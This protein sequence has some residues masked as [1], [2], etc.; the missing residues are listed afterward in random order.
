M[1]VLFCFV[2]VKTYIRKD[3]G[4][5]LA[6]SVMIRSSAEGFV[7][8]RVMSGRHRPVDHGGRDN[9]VLKRGWCLHGRR[10]GMTE[11]HRRGSVMEKALWVSAG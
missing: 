9:A 8:S 1:V 2:R 3:Q 10:P 7:E 6:A 4:P 5:A 11:A